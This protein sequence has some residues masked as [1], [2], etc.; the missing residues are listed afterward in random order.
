[1]E[2]N[3]WRLKAECLDAD[4]EVFFPE[5]GSN[6]LEAKRICA[7]CS[8]VDDCLQYALDNRIEEGV[9]GGKSGIERLVIAG[10]RKDRRRAA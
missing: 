9:W 5:A 2:D 4:P 3:D 10:R 8:V 1:M 6:G 7:R